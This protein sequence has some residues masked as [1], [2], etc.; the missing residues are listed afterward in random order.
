[1][2]VLWAIMP[3][4][5]VAGGKS[6]SWLPLNSQASTS[7]GLSRVTRS[8]LGKP[9]SFLTCSPFSMTGRVTLLLKKLISV[10]FEPFNTWVL[11]KEAWLESSSVDLLY[12][13][14]SG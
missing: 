5:R 13:A 1:M 14:S 9:F 12:P 3:A 4:A 8:V 6:L 7:W 2:P 11:L 10:P